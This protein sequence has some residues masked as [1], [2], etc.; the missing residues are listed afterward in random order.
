MINDLTCFVRFLPENRGLLIGGVIYELLAD[1]SVRP[2]ERPRTSHVR[3]PMSGDS[4]LMPKQ[5]RPLSRQASRDKSA[6]TSTVQSRPTTSR[7]I[8]RKTIPVE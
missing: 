2:K 6:K 3:E 8:L 7:S 1:Q 4:L 5:K